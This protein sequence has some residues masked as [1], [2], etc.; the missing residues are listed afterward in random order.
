[1]K[2][3]LET[4]NSPW[5]KLLPIYQK[6]EISEEFI[7]CADL[8]LTPIFENLTGIKVVDKIRLAWD[9]EPVKYEKDLTS[10]LS[11]K[12]W[13]KYGFNKVNI[14][15]NSISGRIYELDDLKIDCDDIKFWFE[16]LNPELCIHYW[17][18]KW[19]LITFKDIYIASFLKNHNL[20]LSASFVQC[21]DMQL[22]LNF[23]KLTGVN[24][25]KEINLSWE[26]EDFFYTKSELSSF[27]SKLYVHHNW[28]PIN[29]VWKSKSGRIYEFFDEDIDNNDIIFRFENLDILLIQDQVYKKGTLPGGYSK[30][31]HLFFCKV[32]T[33]FAPKCSLGFA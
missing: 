3:L 18:P 23:T 12:L 30:S 1:M 31:G 14:V 11:A 20:Q 28:N 27:A 7:N 17:K 32:A 2:T 13:L 16:G 29:I 33:S 9:E 15:W 26:T 22:S 21:M 19:S 6:L 25:D 8:Q 5:K 10:R 24:I 4:P